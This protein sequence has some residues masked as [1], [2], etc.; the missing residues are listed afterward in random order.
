MSLA[1]DQYWLST[2]KIDDVTH[3]P[4]TYLLLPLGVLCGRR[5]MTMD[6]LDGLYHHLA[7]SRSTM[8]SV[9]VQLIFQS[10]EHHHIQTIEQ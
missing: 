3:H 8:M 2:W 6:D 10:I 5:C 1:K 4:K 9:A 7:G